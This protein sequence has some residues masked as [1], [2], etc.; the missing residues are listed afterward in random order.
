AAKATTLKAVLRM[1]ASI[2]G[3]RSA[4]DIQACVLNF[5]FQVM[6][7]E[8]AAILLAGHDQHRF[9]ASTCHSAAALNGEAFSIDDRA[10][11]KVL[12][13]GITSRE[14]KFIFCAMATP[15]AK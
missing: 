8:H 9:V 10:A 12:H 1:N 6:P 7:A 5:I 3:L 4:D 15:N 2:N 14:D 11:A 13:E